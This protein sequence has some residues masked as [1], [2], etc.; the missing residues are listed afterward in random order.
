MRRGTSILVLMVLVFGIVAPVVLATPAAVPACCRVGG[1]HHCEMSLKSS[2]LAGL[3]SVPETCPYSDL[4]A[5]TSELV[6]LTATGHRI[7]VVLVDT[8]A[9]HPKPGRPGVA[10]K[11]ATRISAD[12]R[13]PNN[14]NLHPA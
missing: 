4:S 12:L 5:V 6:A 1:N 7:A 3:W 8:E 9:G 10:N 14:A 11:A 13:S 2:G